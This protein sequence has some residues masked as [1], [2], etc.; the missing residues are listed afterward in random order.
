MLPVNYMSNAF[1]IHGTGGYPEENWFPW[2]KEKLE[3]LNYNVIVPQFPTPKNQTLENWFKIFE[4]YKKYYT[5]DTILI[6]HSLGGAFLLRVL[7][8]YDLKIKAAYTVA[9][10]IGILPIKNYN[11]DKLFTSQSFDWEKIR[12]RCKKFCV[13]H[14]GNDPY[15]CLENG[16]ELAKFLKTDL[17]FVPDAGHFNEKS[18]YLKFDILFEAIKKNIL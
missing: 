9:V 11:A 12:S 14:S 7:E 6:G 10:P 1:I 15:V 8:K 16:K 4:R 17:I 3:S 18:G 2:L 13:F 5:Q